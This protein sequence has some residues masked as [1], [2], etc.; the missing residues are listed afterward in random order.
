LEIETKLHNKLNEISTR[1]GNEKVLIAEKNSP[2]AIS[3]NLSYELNE[4]KIKSKIT[5][6]KEK[7]I[8]IQFN[9]ESNSG[10]LDKFVEELSKLITKYLK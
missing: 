9:F 7:K 6:K 10:D 2:N 8:L 5:L 4:G 1:G 3:V